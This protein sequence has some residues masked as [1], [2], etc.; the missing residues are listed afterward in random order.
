MARLG[1]EK[2]ASAF[3][4]NMNLLLKGNYIGVI[5]AS[6]FGIGHIYYL[7][8]KGASFLS[9]ELE[10]NID[11]IK[12]CKTQPELSPHNLQHRTDSISIQIELDLFCLKSNEE[13]LFYD[14]DIESLGNV[15]RSN[16]LTRKTR[17]HLS[18]NVLLEPDAIFMLNTNEGKKLFCLEYEHKDYTKKSIQKL[19]KHINA[20]NEKAPSKKYGHD[21]AHRVLMVYKKT[22]TMKS[23]MTHLNEHVT[24][25]GNW[26]LFKS[27]ENLVPAYAFNSGKF[28]L[29]S[30]LSIHENWSNAE[31]ELISMF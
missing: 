26:I 1:I 18:N 12:Y 16:N 24:A 11:D 31:G 7:K 10:E 4:K 15:R 25:L 23:V 3:S 20:L 19:Y 8:R 6:N 27:L 22:G 29:S 5:D 21:K 13:V 30:E 28:N 2:Y 9:R 14:R 17:L